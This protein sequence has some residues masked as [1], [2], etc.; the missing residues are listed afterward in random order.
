MTRRPGQVAR[1]VRVQSAND[2]VYGFFGGAFIAFIESAAFA[3]SAL[4]IESFFMLSAFIESMADIAGG[5]TG[6]IV[7]VVSVLAAFFSPHAAT[8]NRAAAIRNFRIASPF[9]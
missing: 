8:A 1:G 9:R 2:A 4:R 7:A 6:A 5:A 3:E